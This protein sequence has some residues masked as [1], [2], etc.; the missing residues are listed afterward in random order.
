M[1]GACKKEQG[2]GKSIGVEKMGKAPQRARGA[3]T[4]NNKKKKKTQ[5]KTYKSKDFGKEGQPGLFKKD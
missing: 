3:N 5:A 1:K 4:L 2:P